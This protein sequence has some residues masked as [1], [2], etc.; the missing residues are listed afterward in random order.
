MAGGITLT[1]LARRAGAELAGDGDIVIDRTAPLDA[2][3][4]GAIAFLSSARYRSQLAATRASAVI[5]A[6]NDAVATPL[7]KLISAN[8]YATYARVAAILHSPPRPLPGVHPTAVVDPSAR[9]AASAMLGPHVVVGER[10]VVGKR[11]QLHAG[12]VIGDDCAIGDDGVL[13][14]RVVVYSRC[15]LGP[16]AIVHSGVVIGADG[17][18]MAEEDGHWVK[19]PQVGRVVIGADVEIGANTTIDRGTIDDTIIEDDVKLDNQIQIGHNCRIGAH[20]AIAGCVGIAG[21]AKIGRNCKIGGAAMIAGH[22]EIVDGTTVSA[23]S[24]VFDSIETPGVYTGTFPSLPH[25][26]WRH[27]AS[28]TR[29]LREF[30]DRLHALERKLEKRGK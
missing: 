20:T 9:V 13:Y 11:V 14:P 8:P 3:G 10:T 27:V 30:V 18:G 6:P 22:L 19:I 24:G 2:A 26:E 1:E 4:P 15:T 21:S 29:R 7:P 17:F 23:A 5:V 28:A 12:T 16:R 25:R